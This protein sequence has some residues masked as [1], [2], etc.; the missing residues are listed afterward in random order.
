MFRGVFLSTLRS[1]KK[2]L[3]NFNAPNCFSIVRIMHEASQEKT[4]SRLNE[5]FF[6]PF[7]DLWFK[8]PS[9]WERCRSG[10]LTKPIT[11]RLNHQA[12]R[13][14]FTFSS[15]ICCY[16]SFRLLSN[17]PNR[18]KDAFMLDGN[19]LFS[20]YETISF[21]FNLLIRFIPALC[22]LEQFN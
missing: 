10:L 15:T 20:L 19:L 2:V 3:D 21:M 6:I 17:T 16:T 22:N 1:Q 13:S 5:A 8:L 7:N 18:T 11:F 14:F 4:F 12:R 9:Q